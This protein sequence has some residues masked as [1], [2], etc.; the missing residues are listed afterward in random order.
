MRAPRLDLAFAGIMGAVGGLHRLIG[1]RPGALIRPSGPFSPVSRERG[2]ALSGA[3]FLAIGSSPAA[4]QSPDAFWRG[5]SIDLIISSGVGGGYDAYARLV[6][7]YMEKHMPGRPRIIPKNMV[8]AGG[9]VAANYIANV[10]AKDGTV[11][12]QIQNTVPF[13]PLFGRSGAQFDA[14][15]LNYLGSANSETAVVFTWHASPTRTFVDLQNRETVMAVAA[16]SI[17][18]F[19]A[20]A[21]NDLAGAKIKAVAGYPGATEGLLAMERGEVEGHPTIFWSSLKAAKPEWIANRKINLLAQFALKKHREL[22]DAPLILD[23]ARDSEARETIELMAMT[24]APGRPFVAPPGAPADR[25][26]ALRGALTATL[27]DPAFR[28]D[29]QSRQMEID[30]ASGEEIAA[31]MQN[32]YATP[33]PIARRAAKYMTPNN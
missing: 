1:E 28:A 30:P 32:A 25:V 2:W 15:K 18:A 4:A 8:G 6:A 26:E 16:G 12:G 17:S 5:K 3:L 20:A 9:L 7:R 31:L 13:D 27:N 33:K 21:M 14:L 22:P 29:A 24:L 19:H 10:A 23:Y 11:I